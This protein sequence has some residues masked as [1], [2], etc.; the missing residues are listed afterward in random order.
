MEAALNIAPGTT[1]AKDSYKA[2]CNCSK[3]DELPPVLSTFFTI[4]RGRCPLVGIASIVERECAIPQ[5]RGFVAVR[6]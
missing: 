2:T 4:G 6:Y 1:S 5:S 3:R